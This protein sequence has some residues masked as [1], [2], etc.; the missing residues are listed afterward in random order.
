MTL[1]PFDWILIAIAVFF[2]L[3]GIIKG[4]VRELFSL[5]ALVS[6]SVAAFWYYPL[7]LPSIQP[8]LHSKWGQLT[9]ACL[10]IFLAVW[11]GVNVLGFLVAKFLR[12]IWL[13]FLDHTAGLLVGAAKSYVLACVLVVCLLLVPV[14]QE[15]LRDSRLAPSTMPLITQALPYLPEALQKMLS[16]RLEAAPR[17]AAEKAKAQPRVQPHGS[18]AEPARGPDKP[19]SPAP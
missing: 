5:A 19:K 3:K 14:G 11:L 13:G 6:A 2:S 4:A 9:V 17:Q 7:V 16:Q 1:N 18:A 10:S 8:Y 12:L 15:L